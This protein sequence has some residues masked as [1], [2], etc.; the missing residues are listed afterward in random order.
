MEVPPP[1]P[2]RYD[3]IV[4]AGALDELPARVAAAV[5]AAAY[6][7]VCPRELAQLHGGRV[8]EAMRSAGIAAELVVFDG[9][10]AR[11]TRETWTQITD[12]MLELRF[13]RDGCLVAI[14][15][16]VTGDVAGFVAATYMR[17]IPFV[18][19]PTSLLA[20][21]DASVG[22]KTGV[23]TAA[24]KNLVGA[25][26]SPRLVVV[27]PLVLRTLPDEEL[28]S[29]LAEAVKH[30]A[31]LDAGYFDWMESSAEPLLQKDAGALERL[32]ARSIELKAGIVADDPYERGRRAVLNFGHT[33]GHALE[34][35]AGYTIPHG[36]AVAA[37]MGAEAA[38]GEAAGI[39][40][41]GTAGRLA[42]LLGALGLPSRVDASFDELVGAMRVDKKSVRA[43][44]RFVLLRAIGEVARAQDGE[45]TH[46][47]PGDAVA[48]V[49]DAPSGD[50]QRV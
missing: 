43:E 26:H 50:P 45:W 14:G 23:D 20:M 31:I 49:L 22:G 6:A 46:A 47:V 3:V 42:R 40:E 1:P 35:R 13:G 16:G 2:R 36:H 32:I 28:R 15:G 37:G 48:A 29:G 25:F 33:I 30:G 11:K 19:V 27:D 44:P 39:S 18:Q 38:I 34:R 7:L 9:G 12:R 5:P 4:R 41:P 10:E 17:G 8:L 24:G 21:I